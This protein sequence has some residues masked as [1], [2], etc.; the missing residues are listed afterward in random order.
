MRRRELRGAGAVYQW[1]EVI[2]D[3]VVSSRLNPLYHTGTIAV[4]SLAV[5]T[6]TGIYL[7]LFYRVGT[8]A[9]HQSIEGIMAQPFAIGSL[10]RSLHR[11]SSDAAILAALLHGGKMFLNDRFWGARWIGWVTGILLV[12]LVWITGATGYWLVW[13][14][15]AQWLSISSTKFLD[16]LPLFGE[17]LS[18]TF[19]PG[20]KIQNFL[21]FIVLFIHIT[22][23]LLLGFVYWLHVM[24]LAR[25]RFF[26]PRVVLWVTGIALVAASL[27]RPAISGSPAD[28]ATVPGSVP[29]DLFYFA[30][31]PL[32]LL[33]PGTGW[34]LTLG[35]GLVAFALPWVLR[36]PAPARAK[37]ESFACTGCLRCWKDCPYEAI[38]MVPR[39]DDSRYKLEAVVNP[40]KCVGCG[41]CIGACDSAGIVLGG[42]PVSLLGEGV[43]ARLRQV[44]AALA[45]A[46]GGAPP[47]GGERG[48]VL[49]YACRLMTHLEGTLDEA[50]TLP[51]A[52]GVTVMGLPCVGMLHPEMITK[53][54]EQGAKGVFVAGCIPEDCYYR[55]GSL[56]LEERLAG[57]RLPKLKPIPED[58]LRVRWYSPVEVK[59][60]L[61]D[62]KSFTEELRS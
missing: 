35:V 56:W 53:S 57:K 20:A 2:V 58:R 40:A 6:V 38:V 29:V 39:A 7:F 46:V 1:C 16:I 33:S 54:L 41:I 45:L 60:F 19:L 51:E 4:F 42:Q 22:I 37:V 59:R 8:E 25:A 55:E 24:R 9:A 10:M 5:A 21:F 48:P 23:P 47:A 52:P 18:R 61:R 15:Q 14:V 50:G 32:T 28:L 62:V 17:P 13:D 11:Y 34:A 31:A 30:Y 36:G 12:G 26:P 49:V 3:R 44:K 43:T 27:L